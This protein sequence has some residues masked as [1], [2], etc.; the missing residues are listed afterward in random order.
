MWVGMAECGSIPRMIV[1]DADFVGYGGL[2][3]WMGVRLN[4]K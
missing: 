2:A 1:V 3:P 4:Q